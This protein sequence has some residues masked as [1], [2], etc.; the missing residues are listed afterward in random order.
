M[1]TFNH[2]VVIVAIIVLGVLAAVQA[3]KILEQERRI[4]RLEK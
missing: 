1:D 4:E 2:A 3:S